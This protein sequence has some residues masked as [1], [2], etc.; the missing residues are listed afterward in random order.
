[1]RSRL[2]RLTALAGAVALASWPLTAGAA[3]T[4]APGGASATGWSASASADGVRV[5]VFI[6]E[7]I[8]VSN[9][10][11]AGG[12]VAQASTSDLLGSLG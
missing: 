7:F 9:V 5:G 3:P 2:A 10:V 12:P 4:M 11:D 6:N 8:A 1:M